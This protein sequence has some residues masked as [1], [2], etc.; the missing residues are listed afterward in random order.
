MKKVDFEIKK[1][2]YQSN[3]KFFKTA[4]FRFILASLRFLVEKHKDECGAWQQRLDYLQQRKQIQLIFKVLQMQMKT[5]IYPKSA[6]PP[7]F[8]AEVSAVLQN[9]LNL[10]LSKFWSQSYTHS[11]STK[12]TVVRIGTNQTHP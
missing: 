6:K 4:G 2:I 7:A 10:P 11:A 12:S 1:C 3:T 5:R 8:G 9:K